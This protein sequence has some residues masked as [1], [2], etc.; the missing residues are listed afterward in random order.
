MGLALLA[1]QNPTTSLGTMA[2]V[3]L[4]GI[5]GY[6]GGAKLRATIGPDPEAPA[7]ALD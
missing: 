4:L 2:V 1:T 5:V 3:I 7:H 6:L